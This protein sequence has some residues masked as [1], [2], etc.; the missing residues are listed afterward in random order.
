M[1]S[2]IG[3]RVYL[4]T[5]HEKG[6][7]EALKFDA[8]AFNAP[9]P[10]FITQFVTKNVTP[11]RDDD[12][13]RSWFFEG[14]ESDGSGNTKGHVHYGTFGYES[15]IIDIATNTKKYDRGVDDVEQIPL[16]Y[17]FWFPEKRKIA[18]AAFQSFAG[19]SCIRRVLNKINADFENA[20]PGMLFRAQKLL[21]TDGGSLYAKA[22]VKRLRL[23]KRNVEQDVTDRYLGTAKPKTVN[24][25]VK[26]TAG[27]GQTLGLF[28]DI[29]G[30]A[31][32]TDNGVALYDG[33]EFNEAI[34][35]VK[36]GGQF[37]PVGMFGSDSNA[38]VIDITSEIKKGENG[39]PTFDSVSEQCDVILSDFYDVL[40]S[41][42][43]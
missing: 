4:L 2:A 23:I 27:R 22:P 32:S 12:D 16:F 42:K 35:D 13:E 8:S 20:N 6:D 1:A 39:H 25:E 18:F 29:A 37:R 14:K 31:K 38:G 28:K 34:A 41:K 26:L 33:I 3:L 19:K 10:Q 40:T 7:P 5:V 43:N 30:A 21:P 11:V 36:I 24:L 17:E 9:L 15:T